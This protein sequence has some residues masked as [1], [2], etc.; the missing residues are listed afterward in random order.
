[1]YAERAPYIIVGVDGSISGLTAS[2]AV[3]A[4]E[5][6]GVPFVQVEI[7]TNRQLASIKADVS[8]S[9]GIGWFDLPERHNYARFTKPIYRDRP[10]VVLMHRETA[11]AGFYDS[12][13]QLIADDNLTILVKTQFS[14]G[15]RI[16][17]WLETHQPRTTSV[18]LDNVGMLR[19]VMA[20]RADYMLMGQ[21]ES[22]YLLQHSDALTKSDV[23]V[24]ALPDS[25]HGNYRHLMCSLSVPV[26][27]IE[28]LNREIEE[29]QLP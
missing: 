8:P 13:E 22:D 12:L 21:E 2:P 14:Y 16:D 3:R 19:M 28:R 18:T 26:S 29:I 10:T 4:F 1:M 20:G 27:V 11:V 17:S 23:R 6:A 7:P 5:R 15:Q 25:P 9:C 24:L